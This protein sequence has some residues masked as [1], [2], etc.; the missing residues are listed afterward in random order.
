MVNG[1]IKFK[2]RTRTEVTWCVNKG[3][4]T[5]CVNEE[6]DKSRGSVKKRE[7]VTYFERKDKVVNI[8]VF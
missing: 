7:K 4:S 1:Y 8:N 6:K 2:K 3:C 5:L